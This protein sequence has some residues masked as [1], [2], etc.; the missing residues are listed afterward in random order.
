MKTL[1]RMMLIPAMLLLAACSNAKPENARPDWIVGTSAKY[2]SKAYLTGLGQA[3][4]MAV[5]KD[6]A[7]GDL[8]KI[9]SVNISEQ[10]HDASSY[11]QSNAGGTPVMQN[12][13]DVSRNIKTRTDQVL[14]GVEISD[15]WQDPVTHQYYA[16]ATLSRAKAGTA[17]RQQISDLDAATQGYIAAAQS[18]NDLFDKIT[19]SGQAVDA[20][21]TRA[22]LQKDL[23]VVDLTGNGIT[24]LWPLGQL[25]ANRAALL[26]QLQITASADGRDSAAV[27]KILAG[28]LA[29]AGFTVGDGGPFTLNANL[30]YATPKPQSG[31]YWI[32]GTL[33]VTLAGGDRAHGVRRW[34]LKVSG[35]DPQ[36]AQQRLMDQVAQYLQSD[37]QSTVLGFAGSKGGN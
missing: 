2:S 37:I 30:D 20:Q 5:A 27:Q 3:D 9:F 8:A 29:N 34:D 4:S 18:S 36:L 23:Q 17:L 19:A 24:P 6:L 10:S 26:K 13:L 33:Q 28:A 25:Q 35:T 7:R 11:S 31:F 16:L 12:T 15:T 1:A 22:G 21:Q 14:S 32:V